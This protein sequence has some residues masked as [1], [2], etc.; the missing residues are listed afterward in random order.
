MV[1]DGGENHIESLLAV[2][3]R[4]RLSDRELEALPRVAGAARVPAF[5]Q[6]IRVQEEIPARGNREG[7]LLEGDVEMLAAIDPQWDSTRGD[8]PCGVFGTE[9]DRHLV[10]GA[11]VGEHS[12]ADVESPVK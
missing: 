9:D 2:E 10:A 11:G 4:V 7:L 8:R 1:G 6:P 3:R 12:R 5:G